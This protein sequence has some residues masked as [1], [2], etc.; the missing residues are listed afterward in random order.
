MKTR[1]YKNFKNFFEK[2][3]YIRRYIRICSRCDY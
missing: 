3:D 2:I 1:H